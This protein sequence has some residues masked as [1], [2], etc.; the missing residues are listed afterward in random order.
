MDNFSLVFQNV[1]S[2]L[3]FNNFTHVTMHAFIKFIYSTYVYWVLGVW[4][5]T[6]GTLGP[7]QLFWAPNSVFSSQ[8]LSAL[9]FKPHIE[10]GLEGQEEDKLKCH[11]VHC[12]SWEPAYFFFFLLS[13]AFS[14][15]NIFSSC[16]LW[17]HSQIVWSLTNF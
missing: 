4:E 6:F 8:W 16:L 13:M 5:I 15:F 7:S 3:S 11:K 14:F 10:L 12:L 1:P 9:L 2:S 17:K